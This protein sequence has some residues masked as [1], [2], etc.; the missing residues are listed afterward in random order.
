GTAATN[1]CTFPDG[2]AT[3]T[4]A[5]WIFDK[6]GGSTRYT[7]SVVVNNVPPAVTAAANQPANEGAPTAFDLGS[8][9]DPG[10]EGTNGWTVTVDWGD[11][12]SNTTFQVSSAGA[13]G[14]K[15][16]TY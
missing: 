4:V 11:S 9:T 14:T 5:A 3:K 2:P 7:T 6:D 10:A 16:H 8:F 13:L 1:N 15:S 12:T